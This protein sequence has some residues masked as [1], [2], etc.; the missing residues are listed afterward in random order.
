M[1]IQDLLKDIGFKPMEARLIS[2]I[3]IKTENW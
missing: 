2:Q 1:K 3:D